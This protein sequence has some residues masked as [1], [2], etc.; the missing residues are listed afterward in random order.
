[1]S[2]VEILQFAKELAQAMKDGRISMIEPPEPV[3]GSPLG[4]TSS[5]SKLTKV[6][7]RRI[8]KIDRIINDHLTEKDI[9]GLTRDLSANPVPKPGG[10]SWQHLKEVTE[11]LKGL[12]NEI[13][14]LKGSLR[15]PRL[16]PMAAND[17]QCAIDKA[18]NY[19]TRVEKIIRSH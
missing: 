14:G 13:Q 10:G 12:K 4:T 9:Q 6:Q 5:Q 18:Q 3:V 16:D 17:I 1:L 19:I 7:Q 8:D 11:A 15:N 2:D